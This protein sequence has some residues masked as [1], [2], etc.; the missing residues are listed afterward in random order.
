MGRLGLVLW[1]ISVLGGLWEMFGDKRAHASTFE[2]AGGLCVLELQVDIT[3]DILAISLYSHI[4][5]RR[6][7]HPARFDKPLDQIRGVSIHGCF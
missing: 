4:I 6:T 5:T 1:S 3:I 7:H 2:R